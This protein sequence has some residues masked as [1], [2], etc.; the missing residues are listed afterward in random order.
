M[1]Q[2][3]RTAG[4]VYSALFLPKRTR[5]AVIPTLYRTPSPVPSTELK[6]LFP[7]SFFQ[8]TCAINA[9]KNRGAKAGWIYKEKHRARTNIAPNFPKN[10]ALRK[11]SWKME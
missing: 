7:F 9:V 11:R 10:D 2:P 6:T 4:V 3:L 5:E 1:A 8:K